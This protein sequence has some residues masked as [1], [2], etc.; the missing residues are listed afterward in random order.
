[1]NSDSCYNKQLY[2]LGWNM[3]EEKSHDAR[4]IANY[5]LDIAPKYNIPSLTVMQL[6]KLVYLAH[7]WSLAFGEVPL[8]KQSPQAWQYGPVYPHIYKSLSKYGGA[9][10]GDRITD[11]N[12]GI[13]FSPDELTQ[14]QKKVIDAVLRSYGQMHAFELSGITH[15]NNSPWDITMKNDGIYTEIPVTTLTNYFRQLAHERNITG[16]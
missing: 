16:F 6:L 15:K 8:V 5:I 12:T 1:M 7:G 4:A 2:K 13:P 10:I 11:K 3:T 9:P 14:K